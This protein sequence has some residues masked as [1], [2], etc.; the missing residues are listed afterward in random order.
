MEGGGAATLQPTRGVGGV[1]GVVRPPGVGVVP[2]GGYRYGGV[3][4]ARPYPPG[5]VP[6]QQ[7][8]PRAPPY[9][10]RKQ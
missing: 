8:L 7:R 9:P 4:G 6:P 5:A 2:G 10:P 1:G 3:Q